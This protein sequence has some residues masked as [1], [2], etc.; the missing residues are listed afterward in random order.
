MNETMN[1]WNVQLAG[2]LAIADGDDRRLLGSGRARGGAARG[3][4]HA[5]PGRPA[6]L[7]SPPS[8]TINVMSGV[9]D[10][11]ARSLYTQAVAVAGTVMSF[12]L[13]GWWLVTVA[14][15]EP[16][17]R[18][19]V[20][21][22]VVV[23]RGAGPAELGLGRSTRPAGRARRKPSVRR[24]ARSSPGTRS[25]SSSGRGRRGRGRR[26]SAAP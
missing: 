12:V 10:E 25:S 8:E 7:R 15:G 6:P 19:S 22:G 20:F 11:R 4:D 14:Q 26:R 21:R 23:P 3:G 1:N 18:R 24:S 2:V 16:D 13:P 5:R 17:R 9:S